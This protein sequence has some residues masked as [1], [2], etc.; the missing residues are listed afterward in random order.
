MNQKPIGRLDPILSPQSIA[1]IGASRA[2][3]TIGHQIVRNLIDHG[4]TGPVFP[5]NPNAASVCSI[6]CAPS[7]ADLSIAPDL[8]VIAVPAARVIDV[9]KQCGASGVQAL[10]V[11]SAGFREIGGEGVALEQELVDT[12]RRYGMRMVGPNCMGVLNTD[13]AVSMNATFAPTMPPAGTFAFMSQSG[14]LGLS[15]LDY[16]QEYGIGISQFV[17]VGNK[18]DVSGNDLLMQWAMDPKVEVILMYVENFGNPR[19]FLEIASRVTRSKPIVALKSGR[20]R[21]GARA[22][23]THTGAL[24]ASDLAVDALLA[25]AGVLRASSMEELFDIAI[26]F[27][28]QAR[29]RSRR[30]AV[31][32]NA[33]GPGILAADAMAAN[34]LELPELAADT[35]R[36]LSAVLPVEAS[37]KNPLDMIASAQPAS[38]RVALE[39]LLADPGI[40]AAVAIFVPPMGV[41]Q[42]DVAEAIVAAAATAPEKPV[43]AVLMGR[44]GLPQG[45]SELRLA[46][47][48]AYIFPESAARGLAA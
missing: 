37:L 25:Q 47:I 26:A 39:A 34:D 24:A 8:A 30:T 41:R 35:V 27:G 4:F 5:V 7:V 1:V 42:E 45:K 36:K 28:A 32:T 19:R 31:L 9:A 48:P 14:A 13:P 3:N 44:K 10:V 40:D 15:V 16:A 22:A 29:P 18:P 12:V 43:V 17:S 38:Y 46:G 6:P 2:P 21:I 11:I 20:S 23:A 33:G